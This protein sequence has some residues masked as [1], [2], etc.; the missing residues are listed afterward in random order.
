[1]GKF[2]GSLFFL[3][4]LA[5]VGWLVITS[6][7]GEGGFTD[8]PR[9]EALTTADVA[10][11][12]E[13]AVRSLDAVLDDALRNAERAT[14]IANEL[15]SAS[16]EAYAAADDISGLMVSNDAAAASRATTVAAAQNADRTAVLMRS[17]A[18]QLQEALREAG[19]LANEAEQAAAMVASVEESR[20]TAQR[21]AAKAAAAEAE[22][23]EAARQAEV[24]EQV[25]GRRRGPVAIDDTV[26]AEP[27]PEDD[28]PEA[29]IVVPIEDLDEASAEAPY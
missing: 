19:R 24:T 16:A 29:I 2:F 28:G 23:I 18:S 21:A 17:Y 14:E 6:M 7:A 9:S 11:K 13:A 3:G 8:V 15:E 12:G 10:N 22:L 20:I 27:L 5:F 4:T 25:A 26:I 1:M